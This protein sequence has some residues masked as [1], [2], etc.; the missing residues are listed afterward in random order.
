MYLFVLFSLGR[1]SSAQIPLTL[2]VAEAKPAPLKTTQPV[3]ISDIPERVQQSAAVVRA[4]SRHAAPLGNI[5]EIERAYPDFSAGVR[6]LLSKSR[7]LLNTQRSTGLVQN[8]RGTWATVR[9]RLD[10]WQTVLKQRSNDLHNDV[11]ALRKESET[12]QTT[13][14][15]AAQQQLP[16][17]LLEEIDRNLRL[18]QETEQ[19]VLARR[20]E[21]LK[22]QGGVAAL[23]IELDQLDDELRTASDTERAMLFRLDAPP[24]WKPAEAKPVLSAPAEP[25]TAPQ[26]LE[27]L[28]FYLWSLLAVMASQAGIF[29]VLLMLLLLLRRRAVTWPPSGDSAIGKLGFVAGR[30]YS[31]ALL[32]TILAGLS[33]D[34]RA[35]DLL[36]NLGWLLMLVPVLRIIPGIISRRMKA[37]VW[38]LAALYAVNLFVKFFPV[39]AIPTRLMVILVEA[40]GISGLV[41][42]DKALRKT[43]PPSGWLRAT[44]VGVRIAAGLLCIAI[45]GEIAGATGLS[46]YLLSAVLRTTYGALAVYGLVLIVR[47]LLEKAVHSRTGSALV[48]GQL[49]PGLQD[50]LSWG[51]NWLGLIPFVAMTLKAFRVAEPLMR[52]ARTAS[53]QTISLGAI[54][55]TLG[56]AVTFVCVLL[57]TAILSRVLRFLLS[58]G[59]YGRMAVQRGTGEAV[60]KL[61]HYTVLTGGFLLALG[62]AGIDLNRFTLL[63]GAVGVGV[64]LGCRPS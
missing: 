8:L 45:V 30:P 43:L 53:K 26:T 51:L 59:L 24:I 42:L 22:L 44:I 32:L 19:A 6:A 13:K 61:L 34:P 62:A 14:E 37:G 2:P 5:V 21:I 50:N 20:N 49:P 57:A 9:R 18:I 31:A 1:L 41:W 33:L 10:G 46:R 7:R 15:G 40:V 64:G 48:L 29:V 63:A 27:I 54:D 58:A 35:P 47:G 17:D 60:S 12:W 39:Q 11:I 4:A 28:R 52:Y 38:L 3:S 23:S 16:P 36:V 56:S 25:E 55:F